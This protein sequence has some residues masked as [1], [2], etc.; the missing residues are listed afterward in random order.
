MVLCSVGEGVLQNYARKWHIPIDNL[1]FEY[2]VLSI[3]GKTML[4]LPPEGAYI[5]VRCTLS[6]CSVHSCSKSLNK[7]W[8]DD[9]D[10]DEGNGDG[11]EEE[12]ESDDDD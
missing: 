2:E 1:D 7:K 9:D 5:Y 3:E 12:E 4:K 8:N 11:E 6:L 10:D